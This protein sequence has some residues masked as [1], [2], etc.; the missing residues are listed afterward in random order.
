MVF[1]VWLLL[2]L[3]YIEMHAWQKTPAGACECYGPSKDGFEVVG[4]C[5]LRMV[6][7]VLLG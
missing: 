4:F 6:L 7:V 5:S 1:L 2:F 3:W